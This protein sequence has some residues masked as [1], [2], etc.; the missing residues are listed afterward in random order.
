MA[1]ILLGLS[2]FTFSWPFS[3][4]GIFERNRRDSLSEENKNLKAQIQEKDATIKA[5]ELQLGLA[6]TSETL[7]VLIK[8]GNSPYDTFS[9][10]IPNNV[11]ASVGEGIYVGSIKVGEIYEIN[12]RIA[13]AKLL[14][15]SGSVVGGRLNATGIEV[16]AK[17]IG[18]GVFEIFV[19]RGVEVNQGD[20]LI[21]SNDETL[22]TVV[23][24]HDDG[25]L[26]RVLAAIPFNI[27]EVK[28]FNTE[29]R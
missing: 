16:E 20:S 15:S 29:P 21:T 9:L 12:E 14:S 27:Y 13:R 1:L 3:L 4:A 7:P 17:G 26:V 6:G 5:L 18:G 24:I 19:P 22:A 2:T 23:S 28:E 11:S 25:T 8:P 10:L